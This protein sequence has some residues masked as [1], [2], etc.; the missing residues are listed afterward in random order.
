MQIKYC[1]PTDYAEF[2]PLGLTDSTI[3]APLETLFLDK[4]HL[5]SIFKCGVKK[6][7]CIMYCKHLSHRLMPTV[8]LAQMQN[9]YILQQFLLNR[10]AK[11]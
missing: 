8:I 5:I 2:C 4:Y 1:R 7:K 11:V 9:I 10:K 3:S 6:L